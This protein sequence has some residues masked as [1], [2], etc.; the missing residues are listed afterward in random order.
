MV[1]GRAG[2]GPGLS[3]AAFDAT[4]RL[5]GTY[6]AS[7]TLGLQHD[8]SL[9][10]AA[11]GDLGTLSWSFE[12]TV[13]GRTGSG[14][15]AVGGGEGFAGLGIASGLARGTAAAVLAG[16]AGEARSV[17]LGFAAKPE[18]ATWLLL[19]AAAAA[20]GRVAA[21]EAATAGCLDRVVRSLRDR[22]GVESASSLA[23]FRRNRT[24]GNRA[25]VVSQ[26]D[27]SGK[28]SVLSPGSTVATSS[29]LRW[30]RAGRISLPPR[31]SVAVVIRTEWLPT[32]APA[33]SRRKASS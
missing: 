33:M 7:F 10:G 15:S 19:A 11:A 9:P 21:A 32:L 2:A 29:V 5:N 16:T 14:M 23:R 6:S 27:L 25:T 28:S 12:T 20:A 1:C 13:A 4:G 8:Q 18:P 26:R 31:S 17:S 24:T 3:T 30:Y 22:I